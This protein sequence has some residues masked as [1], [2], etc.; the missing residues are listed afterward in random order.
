MQT[1]FDRIGDLA[2]SR[3]LA[4]EFYNVMEA[5]VKTKRILEI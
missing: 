5:N 1:R 4:D 3:A 2:I